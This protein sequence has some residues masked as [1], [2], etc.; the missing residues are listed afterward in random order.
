ME[1]PTQYLMVDRYFPAAETV[2][3]NVEVATLT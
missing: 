2:Q 3:E 1:F